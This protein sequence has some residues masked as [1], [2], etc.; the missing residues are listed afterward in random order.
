VFRHRLVLTYEA[1]AGG[2]GAEEVIGRI[3]DRIPVPDMP[4]ESHADKS[5]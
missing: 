2:I 3:M 5:A 1:V 4:M